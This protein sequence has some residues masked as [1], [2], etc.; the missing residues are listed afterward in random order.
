MAADNSYLEIVESVYDAAT[1]PS[2]WRS[3]LEKLAAPSR[4]MAFMTL[5]LLDQSP[6][7]WPN[8]FVGMEQDWLDAFSAYYSSRVAWAKTRTPSRLVGKATPSE[9]VIPRPDLLKTEW[10]NDFLRPQKLIS[11]IGVTVFREPGRLMSAGIYVPEETE[12]KLA[13]HVALVQR[14]TPHLQRAV[15]VNRQLS[16]A[17]FRWQAAEECF[18]RLAVGVIMLAPDMTVRF[19]NAEGERILRQQD[20]LGRDR[21]GRLLA[22]SSDD[23][24]LLRA[25]VR[26][27]ATDPQAAEADRGGVVRLRR[28][29]G[30][31]PYGV[32]VAAARPP[33]GLLG[34]EERSAILF[35][36]EGQSREP[37]REQLAATFGLTLAESRLLQVLL[38]GHG[39]TEAADR[40]GNSVNTV[41]THLRALFEKLDCSRQSDLIRTVTSHAVWLAGRSPSRTE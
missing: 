33:H 37:S 21:E 28:R 29:S 23:D 17:D 36:S 15:K 10:Y 27:L 9:T 11:G 6:E 30:K 41:K 16:G 35:I 2:L 26:S 18:D 25:S 31:R 32:L 8:L 3:A 14:V 20:G 22:G 24:A 38:Q 19:A 34:R 12:A 5:R 40:L 7:R 13:A 39:L 4:G 1:D